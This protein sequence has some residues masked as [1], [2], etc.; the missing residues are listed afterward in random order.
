MAPERKG[1]AFVSGVTW[2]MRLTMDSGLAESTKRAGTLR[3]PIVRRIAF[4]LAA[5]MILIAYDH[6]A[7]HSQQY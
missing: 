4:L 1:L 7:L 3:M 2:A 6:S 5:V